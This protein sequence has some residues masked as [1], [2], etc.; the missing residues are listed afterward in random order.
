M[1]PRLLLHCS[2]LFPRRESC[3]LG[4]TPSVRILVSLPAEPSI[5][6]V[7]NPHTATIKKIQTYFTQTQ[8][9]LTRT[10]SDLAEA[11]ATKRETQTTLT[12]TQNDLAATQGNARKDPDRACGDSRVGQLRRDSERGGKGLILL[13]LDGILLHSVAL[14]KVWTIP[15]HKTSQ[16]SLAF[17]N[18]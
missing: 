9:N 15:K 7:F 14:R 3:Q 5:R 17:T 6:R 4:Y 2:G 8:S 10:Q 16:K 11:L 12:K 18:V 1:S 13:C